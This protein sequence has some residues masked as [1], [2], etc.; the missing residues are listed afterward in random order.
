[1]PSPPF[2]KVFQPPSSSV[3][4]NEPTD[5]PV[6]EPQA[7]PSLETLLQ[8]GDV[9]RGHS[10]R[11]VTK[12]TVDST[13]PQLNKRLLNKGWPSSSLIE[14]CQA[15]PGCGD[16]LLFGPAVMRLLRE[17]TLYHAALLN[18][19]A[20][21]FAE[22]LLQAGVPLNQ[23]LIVRPKSKADFIAC[24][25]ELARSSSCCSILAWQPKSFLTYTELRKCQLATNTGKGLY[26]LM[27]P[28]QAKQSSSPAGLRLYSEFEGQQLLAG[29]IKQR[30]QLQNQLHQAIA[31][32]LPQQW[33]EQQPHRNPVNNSTP[34]EYR[35]YTN[36][37][38]KQT[39]A[40]KKNGGLDNYRG[41]R[42]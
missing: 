37:Q 2:R 7:K 12:D 15:S 33:L 10:Q 28:A 13:Y 39:I 23:L 19:P 41:K 14:L 32:E 8:Q 31:I 25:T 36:G 42:G 4:G 30:G 20:L 35:F 29:I 26:V 24:F 1:M 5:R 3:Y 9:W 27:R 16:W 22:G 21:P 18:P 11:F 34:R 6:N 17:N 38:A 40:I